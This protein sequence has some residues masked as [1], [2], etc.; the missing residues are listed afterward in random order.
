[1]GAPDAIVSDKAKE[2]ISQD[3]HNFCN[4]IGTTVRA[5]EE[6]TPW[7]NKAELYIKLMKEAVCKDMKES[8]CPLRFWDY[9][10]ECRVRIYSLTSRD[11][12]KVPHMETFGEQG[13]ISNL[14]QFR[15]NEWCYFRDHK[16]PFPHNQEVLGRVLGP[17]RGEGNELSQWVLK[18]N[19]N[20]VPRRTVRAL[21][22]AEVHS[23][24]EKRKWDIFDA[25]IERRWGSPM[26]TPNTDN[27]DMTTDEEEN[28][29][30]ADE[31]AKQ[32]IDIEDS[33]DSQGALMNQ[34]PAYNRLLNTEILVQADEGHVSG[35]VTKWVLGPDGKV[36]GKYDDNP[37]LNSIMYKVELADGRIKEYGAN[38]IAE[39]ML[40]QVDSN[41]FSLSL[42]E[43]IIDYKRDDSVAIPK[44]DKYITTSRGQRRLRK[45]TA[46]WKLLVKWRD[47]SESWVKLSELKESHPVETAEFAKSRGIDNEPVFAWWVPHTLKKRNAVISAMKVRLRKTTHKYGIEISTTRWKLIERMGTQCG[48]MRWPLKGSMSGLHSKYWRKVR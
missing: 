36:A 46:G 2:Q 1:M 13:D 43:G 33:V 4:T 11:H 45:T 24:T 9:C 29:N 28:E 23:N 6:G 37:Y 17:A 39:N 34:L 30:N 32:H 31:T 40:T 21:Q 35:K 41:G 19:G 18:S 22:L 10:L 3:V 20:V 8:N 38:I 26:S 12:I 25:L 16:A 27:T 5:L 48:K 42:M 15:W 44:T 47:Q 14:C 7:S